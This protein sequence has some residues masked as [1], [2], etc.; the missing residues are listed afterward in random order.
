MFFLGSFRYRGRAK[1]CGEPER[2]RENDLWL[3]WDDRQT[4]AS[5]FEPCMTGSWAVAHR[6]WKRGL[7]PAERPDAPKVI[8]APAFKG[9][10]TLRALCWYFLPEHGQRIVVLR[11]LCMVRPLTTTNG[12]TDG[13]VISLFY[14]IFQVRF[15]C[16]M[17]WCWSA[18][19]YPSFT[20]SWHWASLHLLDQSPS[21]D[22][23]LSSKVWKKNCCFKCCVA[24]GFVMTLSEE[25]LL[26]RFKGLVFWDTQKI[27]S[28][29][30]FP[31]IWFHS[32]HQAPYVLLTDFREP[33]HFNISVTQH[34]LCVCSF[35]TCQTPAKS[36]RNIFHFPGSKLILWKGILLFPVR[37]CKTPS[38]QRL[39]PS[40][41]ETQSHTFLK[42]LTWEGTPVLPCIWYEYSVPLLS[43]LG[44]GYAACCTLF[45]ISVY[46]N[47]IN[48]WSIYYLFASMQSVLPWGECNNDWNTKGKFTA[49][50][51]KISLFEKVHQAKCFPPP[52]CF[53]L[54]HSMLNAAVSHQGDLGSHWR[55]TRRSMSLFQAEMAVCGP[56]PEKRVHPSSQ[57]V[58]RNIYLK[59]WANRNYHIHFEIFGQGHSGY[60]WSQKTR[61]W[62]FKKS[63]KTFVAILK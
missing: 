44:V 51:T 11:S 31:S 14:W 26:V 50:V 57:I 60:S 2:N 10:T 13:Y 37:I 63:S 4:F 52:G 38:I 39:L 59:F 42:L 18:V 24:S 15:S 54:E 49:C 1:I 17:F 3:T 58:I 33:K 6:G 45:L 35:H 7:V 41:K 46:Y 34:R 29:D 55:L 28:F 5:L 56:E 22:S 62:V 61:C 40:W 25:Q 48:A 9:L 21:G 43:I 8:L 36:K 16:H 12:K 27:E 32:H 30:L 19:A 47:V 23:L 20:W 53:R